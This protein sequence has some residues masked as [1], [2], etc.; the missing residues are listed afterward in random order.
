MNCRLP[1]F[2]GPSGSGGFIVFPGGTYVADPRSAVTIPSPTPAPSSPPPQVGG[3]PSK[4]AGLSYDRAF[5]KWV[6]VAYQFVSPDGSHYAW[7]S[8]DSIYVENVAGGA[9]IELGEGHAWNIIGVQN[10]GL[11]ATRLNEAGLW[12]LPYS[13]AAKQL[14]STGYWQIASGS[15]AYGTA[16]SAVPDGVANTILRLDLQGGAVVD[17]FTRGGGS[18]SVIGFDASG[19]AVISVNYFTIGGYDVWLTTGPKTRVPLFGSAQGLSLLGPV[20][21]DS[22]GIWIPLSF[23]GYNFGSNVNRQGVGLYA[24]GSGL[25]WMS[26]IGAQIGGG[27][28]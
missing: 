22:H 5:S 17:W 15:A 3:Y 20:V 24:P 13:G 12:L 26:N 23:S 28:S 6:P 2:V 21:A 18:S 7:S 25:W 1:I 9:S 14:T 4:F 27:C 16:T 19:N 10:A 11:Y 8:P